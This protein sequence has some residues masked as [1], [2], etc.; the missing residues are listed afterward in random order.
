[1][2]HL[3]LLRLAADATGRCRRILLAADAGG[4]LG[5]MQTSPAP[6]LSRGGGQ[7]RVEGIGVH[8]GGRGSRCGGHQWPRR[9]SGFRCGGQWWLRVVRF[10]FG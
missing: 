4:M 1:M 8:G 10:G 9:R 3:L 7:V 2:T 5:P 6:D